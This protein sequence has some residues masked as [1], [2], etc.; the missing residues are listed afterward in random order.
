M[1]FV[2]G[3]TEQGRVQHHVAAKESKGVNFVVVDQKKMKR[4]LNR[5]GM[6]NQTHPQ[7]INILR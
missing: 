7:R 4:C 1:T 6:R 3:I 5:I 2:I